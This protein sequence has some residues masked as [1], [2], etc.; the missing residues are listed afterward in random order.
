MSMKQFQPQ[1]KKCNHRGQLDKGFCAICYK[2]ETGQWSS[3]FMAGD[4]GNNPMKF[5]G[6]KRKRR[7]KGK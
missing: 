1:C 6:G 5:K 7:G 3:K 4:K 2:N